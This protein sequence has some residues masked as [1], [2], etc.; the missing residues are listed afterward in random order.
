[1]ISWLREYLDS[2][3]FIL[4]VDTEVF[5]KL[6]NLC[7]LQSHFAFNDE[8]Y[9]QVAG[10]SMGSPLSPVLSNIFM[11][12]FEIKFLPNILNFD[13]VWLRYVDDIFVVLPDQVEPA[14]ILSKLNDCVPQIKFT[15][16]LEQNS[17]LPFLDVLL[18]RKIFISDNREEF[19]FKVFRK[20]T[21][22]DSYVHWLSC[23][24]SHVKFGILKGF[25]LRAFR[26][27]SPEYL[28]EEIAHIRKIFKTLGYP[29]QFI[30]KALKSTKR[31]LRNVKK[32][33]R[34]DLVS[35]GIS[36]FTI[37]DT[38]IDDNSNEIETVN[39]NIE[40][41]CEAEN[42]LRFDIAD[43]F[44]VNVPTDTTNIKK[45]LPREFVLVSS[46]PTNIKKFFHRQKISIKKDEH[47]AGVYQVPC[48]DCD[49]VY[50]GETVDFKRR[51]YQHKYSLQVGD[52]NSALHRHRISNNHRI[53]LE[54]MKLL[55]K[56]DNVNKRQFIESFLIKNVNNFNVH[57]NNVLLDDFTNHIV[58]K[59]SKFSSFLKGLNNFI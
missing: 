38:P 40:R 8:F 12:I 26:L 25:F 45:F 17:F 47:N 13:H 2:S 23:H 21:H 32:Q 44:I 53:G 16:E 51:K 29:S 10:L 14:T 58:K 37:H 46:V 43:K 48:K 3:N 52:E 15:L 4:P 36:N 19:A 55:I 18:I 30:E 42:R 24:E 5:L 59:F 1:M 9:L 39:E 27:C 56:E 20:D 31:R 41:D 28:D 57:N 22:I 35:S 11:E 6:M 34:Q 33:V 50:I 54:E 7:L 49:S